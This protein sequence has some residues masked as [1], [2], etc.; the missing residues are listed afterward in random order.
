MPANRTARVALPS[1]TLPPIL[2]RNKQIVWT[3]AAALSLGS[4]S[5]GQVIISDTFAGKDGTVLGSS[6]S[7][8]VN[9][10]GGSYIL[11]TSND[12]SNS[13]VLPTLSNHQLVLDGSSS[14]ALS[15]EAGVN[16][17]KPRKMTVSAQLA[18]GT[19]AAESTDTFVRGLGVGFY[20]NPPTGS[21]DGLNGN[22]TGIVMDAYDGSLN[23]FY[24]AADTSKSNKPTIAYNS[25]VLGPFSATTIYTLIYT[26]DTKTGAISNVTLSD[27]K[28]V[29]KGTF[30][31]AP[32]QG[33][34]SMN[35]F[36]DAQTKYVAVMATTNGATPE[37]SQV[38]SFKV[39][40]ASDSDN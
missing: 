26:V 11:S 16:V 37:L 36:T 27:S 23:L 21:S 2:M 1:I 29:E 15:L 38:A 12:G 35:V 17:S 34:D 14:A 4:I 31:P 19:I 25:A 7:P 20:S 8:E 9:M 24:P 32:D 10:P 39:T 6:H 30:A 18:V 3:I 40:T 28:G 22:F 13:G 5:H 33:P